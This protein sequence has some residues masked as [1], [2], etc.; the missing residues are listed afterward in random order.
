MWPRNDEERL[1]GRLTGFVCFRRRDD[2]DDARVHLNERIV[3]RFAQVQT[4]YVS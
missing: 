1:R 3:R 4:P 2:A